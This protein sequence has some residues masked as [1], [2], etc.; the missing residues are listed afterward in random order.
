MA[1]FNYAITEQAVTQDVK[2][3][4]PRSPKTLT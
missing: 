2:E 1:A 4:S 3:S